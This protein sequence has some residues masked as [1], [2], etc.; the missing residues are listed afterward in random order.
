MIDDLYNDNPRNIEEWIDS[1]SEHDRAMFDRGY[2]MALLGLLE[3][4]NESQRKILSRILS[5]EEEEFE[6]EEEFGEAKRQL[7]SKLLLLDIYEK[8]YS[9]RVRNLTRRYNLTMGG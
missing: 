6:D 2:V 1:L 4:L 8:H 9:Y 5:L 3:Q 7:E